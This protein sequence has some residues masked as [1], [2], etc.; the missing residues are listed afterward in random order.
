MKSTHLANSLHS[1]K[2][3]RQTS[4]YHSYAN[5]EYLMSKHNEMQLTITIVE[6]SEL[7]T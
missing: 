4:L 6:L 3:Q 1:P 2:T 5:L 7:E